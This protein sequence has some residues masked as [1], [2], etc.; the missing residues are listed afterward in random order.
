MAKAGQ[1]RRK[2]RASPA[3]RRA[4]AADTIGCFVDNAVLEGT[5]VAALKAILGGEAEPSFPVSLKR[6]LGVLARSD[7]SPETAERLGRVLA[8]RKAAPRDRAAAAAYLALLPAEAAEKPLLAALPKTSGPLGIEVLKSLGKVGGPKAL[9]ALDG[10]ELEE[11]DPAKRPLALARLSIALREK[12]GEVA[13]GELDE[14]LDLDWTTVKTHPTPA[15]RLHVV[16]EALA[17]PDWDGPRIPIDDTRAV[18]FVCGRREHIVLLNAALKRGGVV[19]A[20][21]GRGLIAALIV[22]QPEK[23]AYFTVRWLMLTTPGKEGV[24][25][26]LVRP[27]GEAAFEGRATL[28]ADSL[29]FTMRDTGLERTPAEVEGRIGEEEIGWTMRVWRGPLRGKQSPRPLAAPVI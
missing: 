24:R 21:T 27:N 2:G 22:S 23:L 25:M 13:P 20:L 14:A 17:R 16:R 3:L 10:I 26:A 6:A 4:I 1:D 9:K 8:D 15:E 18:S 12:P 11:G 19:K 28:K 5:D 29:V 7:Q